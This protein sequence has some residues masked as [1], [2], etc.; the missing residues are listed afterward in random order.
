MLRRVRT[1]RST[2]DRGYQAIEAVIIVPLIIIFTMLIVQFS[3][4]WHGRH[5]AQAA[6]QAAAR[7]A[8]GYTAT[9]AAGQADGAAYLAQVAPTLLLNAAVTVTRTA[10]TVQV[11]VRAKVVSVIPFGNFSVSEVAAAPV[12]RFVG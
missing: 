7:S 6:A 9:A 8:A 12:E 4:L 5:V 1:A 2:P 11:N 3:L 10:T